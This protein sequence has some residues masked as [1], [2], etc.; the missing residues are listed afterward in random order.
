M[1]PATGQTTEHLH[2]I[3]SYSI[4]YTKLYDKSNNTEPVLNVYPNPFDSEV[5]V[6]IENYYESQA[7]LQIINQ[8]G[9]I[10]FE[11]NIEPESGINTVYINTS[12]LKPSVYHLRVISAN[13]ILNQ[14]LVKE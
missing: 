10:V 9:N 8:T 11:E 6:M 13:N 3:T 5:T 4:H 7:V 2:V 1:S 14:K 12:D